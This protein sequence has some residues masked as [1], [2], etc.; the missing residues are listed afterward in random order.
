MEFDQ[1]VGEMLSRTCWGAPGL[2]A[3][4]GKGVEAGGGVCVA[5]NGEGNVVAVGDESGQVTFLCM[6]WSFFE[7]F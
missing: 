5:A 4:L 2:T 6:L 1:G 7:L 3:L